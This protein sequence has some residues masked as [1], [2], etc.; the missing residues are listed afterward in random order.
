MRAGPGSRLP[1]PESSTTSTAA[2]P[3]RVSRGKPSKPRAQLPDDAS[4]PPLPAL[5]ESLPDSGKVRAQKNLDEMQISD[6]RR[7]RGFGDQQKERLLE[8]FTPHD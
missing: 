1:G 7:I 8:R 2:A 3:A 6:S 4:A 5:L